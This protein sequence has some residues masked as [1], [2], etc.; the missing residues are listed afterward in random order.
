MFRTIRRIVIVTAAVT[1]LTATSA[2]AGKPASSGS[3][4]LTVAFATA[5]TATTTMSTPYG[6][7]YVVSGCGYSSYVTIVVTSPE[8]IAFTGDAPD[9][10]GCISITNFSTQGP[11][12]YR[13][14]AWEQLRNKASIVASTSFD[15]A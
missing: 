12:H 10:A 4:T 14:D 15:I 1:M 3:P 6:T 9:G 2:L 8:A 13:I 11:G 5:S 7:G